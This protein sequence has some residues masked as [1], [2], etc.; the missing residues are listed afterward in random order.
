MLFA[1]VMVGLLST[2]F[3]GQK[4]P[5]Q[6]VRIYNERNELRYVIEG[7]KVYNERHEL[8]YRFQVDP[9]KEGESLNETPQV[10]ERKRKMK[11]EQQIIDFP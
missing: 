1:L 4:P 7:D 8:L 5:P 2:G 9:K 6:P 11:Q 10:K 3:C